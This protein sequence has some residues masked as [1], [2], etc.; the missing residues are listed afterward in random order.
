M[1][2]ARLLAIVAVLLKQ[3]RVVRVAPDLFY[4]APAFERTRSALVEWL[5]SHPEITVAEYRNLISGSRKYA[6]ALLDLFDREAL[7]IRVGDARRLRRS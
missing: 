3:K 5:G 2:S 1:P 4:D 7:T 6:L